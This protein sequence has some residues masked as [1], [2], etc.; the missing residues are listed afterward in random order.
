M[1]TLKLDDDQSS[2]LHN[3]MTTAKEEYQKHADTFRQQAAAIRGG[4]PGGFFADGEPGARAADRLA[5]QFDRQVVD[6]QKLIDA[7]DVAE[8]KA[9]DDGDDYESG[10][11]SSSRGDREDFHSDG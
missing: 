8:Q 6:A 11:Y 7:L 9:Y 1:I 10:T 2:T 4:A 5:E 3:M